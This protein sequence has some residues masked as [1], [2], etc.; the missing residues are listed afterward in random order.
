MVGRRL[1]NFRRATGS[2]QRDVFVCPGTWDPQRKVHLLDRTD[3]HVE[4]GSDWRNWDFDGT[5]I[6]IGMVG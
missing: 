5:G 2:G 4:M 3:I 1:G 6:I